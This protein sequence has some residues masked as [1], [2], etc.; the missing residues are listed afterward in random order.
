MNDIWWR[1]MSCANESAINKYKPV[2]KREKKSTQ[3]SFRRIF[4]SSHLYQGMTRALCQLPEEVKVYNEWMKKFPSVAHQRDKETL[5]YILSVIN[6][7]YF[8]S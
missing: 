6:N 3:E 4:S 7:A 1:D 2:Q 5:E 8:T